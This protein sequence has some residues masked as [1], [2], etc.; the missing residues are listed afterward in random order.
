M[1]AFGCSSSGP[2]GLDPAQS[3]HLHL[4]S[5]GRRS[6]ILRPA[7]AWAQRTHL[8]SP[9]SRTGMTPEVTTDIFFFF[10]NMMR[11][12]TLRATDFSLIMAERKNKPS[13]LKVYLSLILFSLGPKSPLRFAEE[14]HRG[15]QREDLA[16]P[17][18]EQ[19]LGGGPPRARASEGSSSN[20]HAR[21]T[22]WFGQQGVHPPL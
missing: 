3:V 2:G 16:A 4:S 17:R 8:G 11:T 19:T 9:P 7:E 21:V 14:E 10:F 12:L 20:P 18:P 6:P 13:L 15:P 1:Q 5:P 22:A